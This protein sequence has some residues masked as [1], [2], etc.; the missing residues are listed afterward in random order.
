MMDKLK[1]LQLQRMD[2]D[3]MIELATWGRAMHNG[4]THYDVPAPGWLQDSLEQLDG[5]IKRRRQ[6]LL[7]A[8]LQ[9]IRSRKQALKTREERRADLDAEEA[10]LLGQLNR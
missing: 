1:S 8:R 4:Y 3:E 2:V 9:E 6:E 5:E 10:Q 7:Q